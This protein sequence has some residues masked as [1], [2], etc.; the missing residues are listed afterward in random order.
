MLVILMDIVI[1][2]VMTFA[3]TS[4]HYDERC[5]YNSN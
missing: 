4:K 3:N 5:T 1:E 2:I